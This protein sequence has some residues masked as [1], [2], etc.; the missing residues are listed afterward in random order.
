MPAGSL[1]RQE[2]PGAEPW[3]P[4]DHSIPALE[5]AAPS[6]RG[7]ELYRDATQVVMGRGDPHS[8]LMLVGEQPGD[9]E[10]RQGKPFVGPAGRL[11]V[12]ALQEAGIRPERA[13]VTNAVKHFRFQTKG[14][15]R[16]HATPTRW[17]V[18]ACG[19][20][21]LAEFDAVQPQVV[22][23]L[24]ATAGQ[25]VFGPSFRVGVSRGRALDPPAGWRAPDTPPKFFATVHPSSIL[26]SRN[27]DEDHAA[28]VA[29]L[30]VAADR[31]P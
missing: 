18:T 28:L 12:G 16:I 19:P 31:L 9:Q 30:R 14:K 6:C 8:D 17:N 27:R 23:V 3:V 15:Q 10:D 13:Y 22:V 2:Y 29:D 5:A 20:W 24:G 25:A 7:C 1:S 21:L 11:L 26:R 4:E